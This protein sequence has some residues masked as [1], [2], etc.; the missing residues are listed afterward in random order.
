MSDYIP[1]FDLNLLASQDDEGNMFDLNEPV[2]AAVDV[3]FDFNEPA[4]ADADIDAD[5]VLHLDFF[6]SQCLFFFL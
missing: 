3:V 6:S 4:D 2:D 5:A 1:R